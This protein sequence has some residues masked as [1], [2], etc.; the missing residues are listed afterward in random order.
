MAS[1]ND[2]VF[3]RIDREYRQEI[4]EYRRP[5]SL[6]DCADPASLR[7]WF[8]EDHPYLSANDMSLIAKVSLKTVYRW[9]RRAGLA[10]IDRTPPQRR[11]VFRLDQTAPP[12]WEAGTWLEEQYPKYSIRQIARAIGRSYTATRRALKR[13]GVIFRSARE[14][15]RSRHRCCRR[16]WVEQMYLKSGHSLTTL[17]RLAGVSKSTISDWILRFGIR[18]RSVAE[19]NFLAARII[20]ARREIARSPTQFPLWFRQNE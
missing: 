18:V 15:V 4:V 3:G 2:K 8:V 1:I 11:Q 5:F 12:N 6:V 13:R 10:G 7:Q 14:A 19:Q 17:A 20:R 9:R 16:E